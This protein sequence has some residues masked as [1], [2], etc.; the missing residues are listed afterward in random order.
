MS[1]KWLEKNLQKKNYKT[2]LKG[3]IYEVCTAVAVV[4]QIF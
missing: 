3:N 4:F 1:Q 2:H